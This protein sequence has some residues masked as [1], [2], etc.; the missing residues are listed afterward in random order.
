M[1]YSWSALRML[2][3]LQTLWSVAWCASRPL[4]RS[5]CVRRMGRAIHLSVRWEDRGSASVRR[6]S[7]GYMKGSVTA[8]LYLDSSIH[9]VCTVSVHLLYI[10]ILHIYC[11]THH[12]H[13]ILYMCF[14]AVYFDRWN[15][16]TINVFLFWGFWGVRIVDIILVASVSEASTWEYFFQ[17]R[18][19]LNAC[20]H[21]YEL[22]WIRGKS[23]RVDN[24]GAFRSVSQVYPIGHMRLPELVKI[25]CFKSASQ[26]WR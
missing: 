22:K 26:L 17:S 12:M 4:R 23:K 16:R 19:L 5:L 7:S 3:H 24:S 13:T 14:D 9:Q 21:W 15:L 18:N 2:T 6:I 11:Y 1:Y 8:D 20:T 25:Q 10:I